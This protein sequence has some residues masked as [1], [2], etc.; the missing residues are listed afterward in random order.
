MLVW[1]KTILLQVSGQLAGEEEGM[2]DMLMLTMGGLLW[3][4]YLLGSKRVRN[5]FVN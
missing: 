2:F 3:S 1:I 5:T 4:A